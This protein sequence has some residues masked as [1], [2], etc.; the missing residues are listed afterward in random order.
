MLKSWAGIPR[1]GN[2]NV[3]YSGTR[4]VGMKCKS[5][6]IEYKKLRTIKSALLKTS[7]DPTIRITRSLDKLQ[8][9]NAT[10]MDFK[11]INSE[12]ESNRH[13]IGY[14]PKPTSHKQERHQVATLTVEREL[15]TLIETT[16]ELAFQGQ[17]AK[18]I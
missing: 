9:H 13:G 6:D 17:C 3:L 7:S 1:C 12:R 16:S 5:L 4:G 18:M 10:D 14:K 15:D 8:N 2:P 11:I